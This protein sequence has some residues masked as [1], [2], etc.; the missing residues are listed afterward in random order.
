MIMKL[1]PK[2]FIVKKVSEVKVL[3]Q[4]KIFLIQVVKMLKQWNMFM[5]K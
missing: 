4:L 3:F 1:K 5:I 2:A